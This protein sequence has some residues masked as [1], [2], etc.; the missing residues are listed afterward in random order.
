M[1]F[2]KSV[3]KPALLTVV[4]SFLLASSFAQAAVDPLVGTWVGTVPGVTPAFVLTLNVDK[5][6]IGQKGGTLRLGSPKSCTL[7]YEVVSNENSKAVFSFTE[8]GG[9]YCDQFIMGGG[10]EVT[11]PKPI[12]TVDYDLQSKSGKIKLSG[13]LK[14]Q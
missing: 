12:S 14:R 5:L 3:L 10:M 13:S 6:Q 1:F 4:L 7:Q 11:F 8:S 9:G 2:L